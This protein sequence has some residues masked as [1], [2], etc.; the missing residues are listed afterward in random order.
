ME[1]RVTWRYLGAVCTNETSQIPA[2]A[3]TTKRALD[4][5]RSGAVWSFRSGLK[6]E[7]RTQKSLKSA[8][9]LF[10]KSG[11]LVSLV[12]HEYTGFA[13][14]S[15]CRKPWEAFAEA[16]LPRATLCRPFRAHEDCGRMT[17]NALN[18]V[19]IKCHS[20][21]APYPFT[22]SAKDIEGRKDATTDA[23]E[24]GHFNRGVR[25]RCRCRGS[26]P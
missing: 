11:L 10:G 4:G 2:K 21:Q 22:Q 25:P 24:A 18:C 17:A 12:C 3:G 9:M 23:A 6:P 1:R 13:S 16:R 8:R 5:F 20:C 15:F 14:R 7:Q 26:G 19:F